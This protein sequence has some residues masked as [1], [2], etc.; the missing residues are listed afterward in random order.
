[1]NNIESIQILNTA[2]VKSKEKNINKSYEER[3]VK[4]CKSPALEAIN[5]S[6]SLLAEKQK[7]SRDQAASQ[8]IDTIRDLDRIWNDY[9]MMEGIDQLKNILKN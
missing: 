1:M 3:L 5:S 4:I 9:V 7:I 2:I 6:I 8:I